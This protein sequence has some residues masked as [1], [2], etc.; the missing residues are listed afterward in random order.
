M[1]IVRDFRP[2]E[3]VFLGDFQDCYC[4]S[5]YTKTPELNFNLLSEELAEGKELMNDIARVS[6]A[7][8]VV[9]LEGNHERRISN[10]INSYGAKLGGIYSTRGIL[11]VPARWKYYTYGQ[12]NH[13]RCG[14]WVATHGSIC[15]KYVASAMLDKYKANVIFGHTHRLQTYQSSNFAGDTLTAL[16]CGWLG[17]K[18]L[19]AEYI[20]NVPDAAHAIALG[21]W[22][23]KGKGH[24]QLIPI[25]NYEAVFNGVLY[26]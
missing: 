17:D 9:F 10:Y 14:D 23:R 4:V 15:N 3:L 24:V 5:Q 18:A 13:H 2:H 25:V 21:Y 7:Q 1:D 22:T 19:A 20:H 6:R 26:P 8:S 12:S 11:G 16:T